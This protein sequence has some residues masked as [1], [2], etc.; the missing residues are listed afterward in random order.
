MGEAPAA[1]NTAGAAQSEVASGKTYW[2]LRNDGA[3]GSVWGLDTG[4]AV[5]GPV[6]KTG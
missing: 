6:P 3:G 5:S 4:T 1:D 2:S